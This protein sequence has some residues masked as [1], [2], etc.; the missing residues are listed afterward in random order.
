MKYN[1]T[2]QFTPY[3]LAQHLLGVQVFLFLTPNVCDLSN[4]F[5]QKS[6]YVFYFLIQ[7]K[8]NAS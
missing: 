6:C 8:N 5:S 2:S 7:L 1:V 3:H 4:F